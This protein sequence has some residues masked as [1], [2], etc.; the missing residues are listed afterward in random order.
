MDKTATTI[1]RWFDGNTW[2]QDCG[3]N[4]TNANVTVPSLCRLNNRAF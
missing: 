4:T 2:C 1:K 3:N